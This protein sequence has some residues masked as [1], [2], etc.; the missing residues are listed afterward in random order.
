V[1]ADDCADY[2]VAKRSMLHCD[3]YLAEGLP[4]ATGGIEGACRHLI[5]DRLDITGARWSRGHPKTPLPTLE[6]GL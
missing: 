4:I 2:L 1:G 6:R 5:V 3:L